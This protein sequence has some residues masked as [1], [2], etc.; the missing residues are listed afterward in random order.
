MALPIAATTCKTG[1]E[2]IPPSARYQARR[3]TRSG[4]AS[5]I[6]TASRYEPW[7]GQMRHG[8]GGMCSRPLSRQ[9][10]DPRQRVEPEVELEAAPGPDRAG[11][12]RG[13]PQRPLDRAP[14]RARRRRVLRGHV[15]DALPPGARRLQLLHHLEALELPERRA[16]QR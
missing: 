12:P 10:L 5:P 7:L 6:T 16:R 14:V 1:C 9:R 2:K 4:T 8:P 13:R 15:E 11:E 3:R